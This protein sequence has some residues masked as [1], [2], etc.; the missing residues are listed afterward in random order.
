MK[1]YLDITLMPDE[2]CNL[3]FLWHKVYQQVHLAIVANSF[4]SNEMVKGRNGEQQTLK[5]SNVAMSFPKYGDKEY[6]KY[7]D[8]EYPLGNTLRLF[9]ETKEQLQQL[10]INTLLN[11]LEDYTHCKSIKP[12]DSSKI[13][14]HVCFKRKQFKSAARIAKDINRRAEYQADKG[15]KN[16]DELKALLI[17]KSKDYDLRSTL[18]FINLIS[19]SSKP[20]AALPDKDRFLL[21]IEMQDIQAEVK[22]DFTC[23]GLS[24][25][26]EKKQATV[27]WF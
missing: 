1:Y 13:E 7:G 21:F 3:V 17:E 24:R 20:D 27:P 6:P 10:D 12:I 2:G 25:R 16:I 9:S 18:P 15:D 26:E 14:K 19:L 23:Y 11:R 8:K 4:V 5:K 22:G